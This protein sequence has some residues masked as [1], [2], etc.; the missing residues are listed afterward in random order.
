MTTVDLAPRWLTDAQQKVWRAYLLGSARLS[1]R[2]DAHL[3]Q[4][5]I[6]LPSTLR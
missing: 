2:M 1:E 4:F 5:G 6:D 3:R